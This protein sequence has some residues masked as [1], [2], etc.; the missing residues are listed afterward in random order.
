MKKY[1]IMTPLKSFL[2]LMAAIITF[3]IW[4]ANSNGTDLTKASPMMLAVAIVVLV[5]L[6]VPAAVFFK[7]ILRT[8]AANKKLATWQAHEGQILKVEDAPSAYITLYYLEVSLG[9]TSSERVQSPKFSFDPKEYLGDKKITVYINPK[10]QKDY[11]VDTRQ[12]FER[13]GRTP[14]VS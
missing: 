2:F 1:S 14:F 8:L 10:N 12:I 7:N 11:F 13:A 4:F 3:C 5:M 9:K 6:A